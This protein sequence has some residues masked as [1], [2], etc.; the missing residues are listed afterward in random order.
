MPLQCLHLSPTP[1]ERG[2]CAS[3]RLPTRFCKVSYVQLRIIAK[4]LR[5][6]WHIVIVLADVHQ[7]CA[8]VILVVSGVKRNALSPMGAGDYDPILHSLQP[9]NLLPPPPQSLY[10]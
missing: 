8:Y 5:A 2:G 3:I 6:E 4:L 7:Y 1:S 10:S 9:I